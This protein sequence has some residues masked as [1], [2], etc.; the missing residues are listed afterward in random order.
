MLTYFSFICRPLLQDR[1]LS[2]VMSG[3]EIM[4][5][6]PS[7]ASVLYGKVHAYN[8]DYFLQNFVDKINT[9]FSKKGKCNYSYALGP[10]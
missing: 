4:N 3:T 8:D 10:Y 7:A 5:D 1:E 6:D 2:V 9:F